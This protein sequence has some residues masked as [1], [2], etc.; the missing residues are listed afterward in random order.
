MDTIVDVSLVLL[1]IS[2]LIAFYRLV[3]GPSMPDR[4]VALDLIGVILIGIMALF[5]IKF[6]SKNYFDAMLVLAILAFM[7]TT[8]MAK[9]LVKGVIID[10]DSD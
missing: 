1:S 6:V 8:A 9:F 4:V 10:R 7:G 2:L 3:K 5:S